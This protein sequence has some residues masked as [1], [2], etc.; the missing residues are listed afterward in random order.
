M[1]RIALAALAALTLAASPPPGEER[2]TSFDRYDPLSSN[3]VLAQRLMPPLVVDQ[4]FRDLAKRGQAFR[5][6][7]VELAGESFRITRNDRSASPHRDLLWK[8]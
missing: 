5:D 4:A 8:A 6:Q 1:R 3:Q 7:P 2:E